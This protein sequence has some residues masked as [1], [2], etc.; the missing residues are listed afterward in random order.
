[1]VEDLEGMHCNPIP[2]MLYCQLLQNH[3]YKEDNVLY[4][5]V[6]EALNDQQKLVVLTKY[7][8]V[9]SDKFEDE[10]TQ[11]YLSIFDQ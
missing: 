4:P 3:I 5:M 9:I 6:E 10:S 7:D 8:E 2:V 1:M 11:R